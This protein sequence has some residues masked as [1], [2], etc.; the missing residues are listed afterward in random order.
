MTVSGLTPREWRECVGAWLARG[1]WLASG[2]RVARGWRQPL[3]PPQPLL[4]HGPKLAPACRDE[5]SPG[6]VTSAGAGRCGGSR[7][8]R[9]GDALRGPS[10]DQGFERSRARSSPTYRPAGHRGPDPSHSANLHRRFAE[11][12]TPP[13]LRPGPCSPGSGPAWSF[14]LSTSSALS[15]GWFAALRLA[16]PRAPG[17]D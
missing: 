12:R 17:P 8:S 15:L 6:A 13:V 16:G 10:P 9:R 2:W 1:A 7:V 11:R 14:E 4:G 5:P 3:L